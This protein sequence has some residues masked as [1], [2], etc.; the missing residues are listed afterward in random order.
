MKRIA[1]KVALLLALG[2][3]AAVWAQPEQERVLQSPPATPDPGARYL[4]YLHGAI[5]ED[6]GRRPRHPRFGIYE[7]DAVLDALRASGAIVISERRAHGTEVRAYAEK[8]RA[9]VQQLL[10][11]GV[12]AS[13]IAIVGFSKG[14]FITQWISAALNEPALR[15]VLLGACP[16]SARAAPRMHGRVLSIIERSDSVPSCHALFA[17][18]TLRD[19]REIEIAIGGQ[20][21]AFYKPNPAWLRP[22]LDFVR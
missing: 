22:L 20:H 11:D 16:G 19:G 18:S 6:A 9:Q 5:I 3:H 14:G 8:I 10:D 7:Y 2:L 13:Q 21:G 4:F 17:H 1:A 15:Y 12:P